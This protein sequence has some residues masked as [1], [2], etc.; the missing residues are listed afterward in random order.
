MSEGPLGAGSYKT[1][2]FASLPG[3]T[4]TFTVPAGWDAFQNWAILGPIGTEAPTGI[5]V[6]FLRADGL[7]GDPCHWNVDGSASLTQAGDVEVGPSVDECK[8]S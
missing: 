7:F 2:P 4:A 6:G 8:P 5:G 1:A 3:L